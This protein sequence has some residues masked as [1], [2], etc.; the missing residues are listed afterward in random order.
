M[1]RDVGLSE[2]PMTAE[3]KAEEEAS[4]K[5]AAPMEPLRSD[6]SLFLTP[7]GQEQVRWPI[8]AL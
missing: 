8:F 3:E 6:N 5:L 2:P 7:E 1:Q 4:R